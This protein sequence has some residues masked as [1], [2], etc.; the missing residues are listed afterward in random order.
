MR[1]RELEQSGAPEVPP[2]RRQGN[3]WPRLPR[4]KAGR[5]LSEAVEK[6]LQDDVHAGACLRLKWRGAVQ[7]SYG[8]MLPVGDHIFNESQAAGDE[9][10]QEE[11]HWGF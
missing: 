9:G 7:C 2:V 4:P 3:L 8:S 1:T 11:P 10:A 6:P 5:L